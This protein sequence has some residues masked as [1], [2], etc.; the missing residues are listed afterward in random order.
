MIKHTFFKKILSSFIVLALLFVL[1][2]CSEDKNKDTYH[3]VYLFPD[4]LLEWDMV[5]KGAQDAL[6]SFGQEHPHT[7]VNVDYIKA[8]SATEQCNNLESFT[9]S[10][11]DG[12]CIAL[13]YC[14]QVYAGDDPSELDAKWKADERSFSLISKLI[15]QN[16]END[17]PVL[18]FGTD[19]YLSSDD[20]RSP[21]YWG[22]SMESPS[23]ICFIGSDNIEFGRRIAEKAVETHNGAAKFYYNWGWRHNTEQLYR[24]T[25]LEEV[26]EENSTNGSVTICRLGNSD[27]HHYPIDEH[28]V[29]FTGTLPEAQSG[30]GEEKSTETHEMS[31]FCE[32]NFKDDIRIYE[33]ELNTFISLWRGGNFISDYFRERG[34]NDA[35]TNNNHLIILSEDSPNVIRAVKE[36]FATYTLIEDRYAWGY[37]TAK[38]LLLMT[39]ENVFPEEDHLYTPVYWI[40][41]SSVFDYYAD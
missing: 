21:Y 35:D 11:T 38:M 10:A 1:P 36:H 31:C 27:G 6:D 29:F 32:Q 40:D 39:I 5:T 24:R 20:P 3:F 18:T 23:R 34:W 37:E 19:Q 8:D 22:Q 25:G 33:N 28:G 7:I 9:C 26:I 16:I 13:P 30:A 14:P 12:I 15:K 41:Y 4:Q 2:S 17:T